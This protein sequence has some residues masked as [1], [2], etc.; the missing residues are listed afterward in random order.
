MGSHQGADR[1]LHRLGE[2]AKSLESEIRLCFDDD[3]VAGQI[4]GCDRKTLLSKAT[5]YHT[6]A[7]AMWA[8][9]TGTEAE[10]LHAIKNN[11]ESIINGLRLSGTVQERWINYLT[12]A[13]DQL[14]TL[15]RTKPVRNAGRRVLRRYLLSCLLSNQPRTKLALNMNV[16]LPT[17]WYENVTGDRFVPDLTGDMPPN[18]P[19]GF[20]YQ[21]S[22]FPRYL[23]ES[24]LKLITSDEV[25]ACFHPDVRKDLGLIE[26]YEGRICEHCGGS[27]TKKLGEP[28]PDTW[29]AHGS[30][31][32]GTGST[33]W[34][35]DL[36]L[37]MTRP[38][39]QEQRIANDRGYT[40]RPMGL[41]RAILM[42]A[43]ACERCMNVLLWRHGL[44][45]GYEENTPEWQKAGT[46]CELC[47]V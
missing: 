18:A 46:S 15:S 14:Q 36:V 22:R 41:D 9:S 37:A 47:S 30:R 20:V 2:L 32:I 24:L 39:P 19:Q 25:N 27:Q 34:S 35:S 38:S 12:L 1:G 16:A 33:G 11:A 8:K 44:S 6:E 23:T 3:S 40:I 28:W 31:E 45:D 4:F 5:E 29:N 26:G 17:L 42:A 10:V 43:T 7:K 13:Q 21:R